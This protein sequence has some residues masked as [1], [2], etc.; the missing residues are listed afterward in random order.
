MD[1]V[2]VRF[3]IVMFGVYPFLAGSAAFPPAL[4]T[5]SSRHPTYIRRDL[6][7]VLF[8]KK[9]RCCGTVAEQVSLVDGAGQLV[10]QAPCCVAQFRNAGDEVL[11]G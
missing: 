10:G 8:D 3:S 9:I 4:A 5:R 7:R 2:I 11:A 1:A 6:P